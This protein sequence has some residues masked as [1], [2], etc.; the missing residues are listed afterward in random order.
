MRAAKIDANQPEIVS[1][2]RRLGCQVAHT[3]MVG[4]GFPDIVILRKGRVALVEI[5]DGAKPPSARKLTKAEAEFHE[6]WPVHIVE[7]TGD[8]IRLVRELSQ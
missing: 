4:A 8:A 6:T 2:F 5:K 3:H 1:A 7:S